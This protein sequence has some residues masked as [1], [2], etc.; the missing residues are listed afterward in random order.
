MLV[1]KYLVHVYRNSER[2]SV[3]EIVKQKDFISALVTV[4]EFYTRGL[5]D[6]DLNDLFYLGDCLRLVN[7]RE[8]TWDNVDDVLLKVANAQE[9]K[10]YHI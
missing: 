6:V 7:G 8:V 4:H 1:H 3:L 5:V 9:V 2:E 10:A